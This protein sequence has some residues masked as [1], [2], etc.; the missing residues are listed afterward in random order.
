[1][2][3]GWGLGIVALVVASMGRAEP[4]ATIG[5]WELFD[6]E[7]STLASTTTESGAAFGPVCIAGI[8]KCSY[9]VNSQ[10]NCEDGHS[11]PL[12][13]SG[14]AGAMASSARCTHVGEHKL[15]L[16]EEDLDGLVGGSGTIGVVTPL[17]SGKFKVMR[18]NMNGAI[19]IIA[20]A[21]QRHAERQAAPAHQKAPA[22]GDQHT[23]F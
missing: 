10:L 12:L 11:A 14:E 19:P 2:K 7:T 20:K 17:E 22:T 6:S 21:K 4:A 3:S 1:M 9:F 13:L 18:F 5:A 15:S 8:E 16:F 23:S